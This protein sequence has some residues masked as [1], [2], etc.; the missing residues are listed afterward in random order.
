MTKGEGG[1]GILYPTYY[2]EPGDGFDAARFDLYFAAT[3][4]ALRRYVPSSVTPPRRWSRH[5]GRGEQDALHARLDRLAVQD[6]EQD[7][8]AD[9]SE[10]ASGEEGEKMTTP[11]IWSGSV[12]KLLYVPMYRPSSSLSGSSSP[13]REGPGSSESDAGVAT[14]ERR[15]EDGDETRTKTGGAPGGA[16]R[17]DDREGGRRRA[18]RRG[19]GRGGRAR[20]ASAAKRRRRRGG[21]ADVARAEGQH[22]R[23]E[24]ARGRTARGRMTAGT[25]P[26]DRPARG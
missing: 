18:P 2:A 16:R 11:L 19:G 1:A 21:G 9:V 22:R 8:R 5:G 3:R 14:G 17:D 6:G 20:A 12:K 13:P 26:T 15:G 25:C 23:R 10:R 4:R 24:P 7:A